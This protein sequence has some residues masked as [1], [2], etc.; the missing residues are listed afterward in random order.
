MNWIVPKTLNNYFISG[1][2]YHKMC[3]WSVCPR[4]EQKFD[5]SKIEENDLVF[6]NLDYVELFS[7]YLS[8]NKSS[9]RFNLIT[10]NSD[11]DFDFSIFTK[12]EKFCKKIYAINSTVSSD[13]VFKIP[14]GFND[15]S[16]IILDSLNIND[17]FNFDKKNLVY[18]NFKN[19]HHPS[20]PICTDYF[21]DFDWISYNPDSNFLPILDFY[22]HLKSFKYCISP[23]GTGIDTH[24]I[25][26]CLLFGVLPIVKRCELDEL[27]E[28]LPI[29]LVDDWNQITKEFLTEKYDYYYNNYI[30]WL[31]NNQNWHLPEFWIK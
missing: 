17:F 11:R 27:Y 26:E 29:V 6:L 4:Y 19:H 20:R 28:K 14:L 31:N 9:V 23:R 1:Y 2:T 12:L 10:Q 15:Q 8:N 21:K 13:K 24:R 18:L 25:Y 30:N 22:N 5:I 7:S 3:K 16:T